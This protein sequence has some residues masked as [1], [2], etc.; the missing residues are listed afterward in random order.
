MRDTQAESPDSRTSVVGRKRDL[1]DPVQY[2]ESVDAGDS[3]DE[4]RSHKRVKTYI[5]LNDTASGLILAPNGSHLTAQRP[6]EV[7]AN[8]SSQLEREKCSS[9]PSTGETDEV[10][11]R[12]LPQNIGDGPGESQAAVEVQNNAV[13]TTWNT[14]VQS[15]LRTSFAGKSKRRSRHA[16]SISLT[17]E[18]SQISLDPA[19]ASVPQ[20]EISMLLDQNT[21][22]VSDDKNDELV[23][24]NKVLTM[25]QTQ[26]FPAQPAQTE[27]HSSRNSASHQGPQAHMLESQSHPE[28][29]SWGVTTATE[30]QPDLPRSDS[31][32]SEDEEI[33]SEES[34]NNDIAGSAALP[35]KTPTSARPEKFR[36]LPGREVK[37]L[38]APEK[39]AYREALA[40]YR[41]ETRERAAKR[42]LLE[43]TTA[44]QLN[45]A[46]KKLTHAE[47]KFLNSQQQAEYLA[48][49]EANRLERQRRVI[50]EV[51]RNATE[52]LADPNGSSH[53]TISGQITNGFTFYPRKCSPTYHKG[54]MNFPLSEIL[55][56]G[57]PIHIN[58]F[59]FNVFAP[60]FLA[61]HRKRRDVLVQKSL[62]AA[63]QLYVSSFYSHVLQ[64]GF[65][66]RLRATATAPDA[67]TLEEAIH[68]ADIGTPGASNRSNSYLATG[69]GGQVLSSVPALPEAVEHP[70]SAGVGETE[71]RSP[72]HRG[73]SANPGTSNHGAVEPSKTENSIL[74]AATVEQSMTDE[75][76]T[77]MNE[78][79]TAIVDMGPTEDADLTDACELL[80]ESM[81]SIDFEIDQAELLLQQKY[82]PSRIASTIP[83]CLSCGRLGHRSST[84]PALSCTSCSTFGQHSTASCPLNKRCGKCRER[85][86][87]KEDCPEKLSRSKGEAIACDMC[88]SK[89]HLE[90]A[91]QYIWRSYEPK[92]EEIHT[93]RDIPVHCYMC[94]ESDHYGPECGL[95][96]GRIL[97]GGNTWSRLNLEKYVD[98]ASRDRAVS[99]GVD[100]SIPPRSNKQFSI[101]G[102]ANDPIEIDDDSDGG[103][104]FIRAKINPPAQSGHI[105]F[106]RQND[107]SLPSRS[108]EDAQ[109]S[110][111][112][113]SNSG[114]MSYRPAPPSSMGS[115]RPSGPRQGMNFRPMQ[116]PNNGVGR[117]KGQKPKKRGG[118]AQPGM[119]KRSRMPKRGQ[120]HL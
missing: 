67:L 73:A 17:G 71:S 61:A 48:A 91:C 50:E 90:I 72:K 29:A 110:G 114:N 33:E 44:P 18:R 52:S 59:S 78:D 2:G 66:D 120:D 43:E 118:P 75:I 23:D 1:H 93:V 104:G 24:D 113:Q 4:E 37:L 74:E 70:E 51:T 56:E 39:E 103:E 68:L 87:S 5:P 32:L 28:H 30:R 53:S 83:R 106:G 105:R 9:K 80:P 34:V 112:M 7:Q 8:D 10:A 109:G 25:S 63:F 108:Y 19:A 15:G 69:T 42:A 21:S 12:L 11:K 88:G 82:F 58:Q 100:Y 94:G 64:F 97:S 57:K 79:D 22:G 54:G 31:G 85:G 65:A 13:S 26:V 41:A 14:G 27:M 60:A 115:N 81:K 95:H 111:S 107:Q 16:K 35:A 77:A 3:S 76:Q 46:V 98:P 92:P 55:H 62:V 102:K 86:H 40:A 99:A 117:G 101:K 84:C 47:L 96:R 38:S 36:I 20:E 49:F 116:G 119:K 6:T 89:D 45:K